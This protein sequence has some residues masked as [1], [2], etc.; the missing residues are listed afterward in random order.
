MGNYHLIP[1]G[2]NGLDLLL[3][4]KRWWVAISEEERKDDQSER[5]SELTQE[6]VDH[7]LP[8]GGVHGPAD[9]GIGW[10]VRDADFVNHGHAPGDFARNLNL[11]MMPA[12]AGANAGVERDGHSDWVRQRQA[13]LMCPFGAGLQSG[14]VAVEREMRELR[15]DRAHEIHIRVVES[16]S[17]A[18]MLPADHQNRQA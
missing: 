4:E 5:I 7:F 8:T 11:H 16:G 17:S 18:A 15:A 10:L 13:G 2:V 9:V 12:A 1:R 14:L 3:E 6:A